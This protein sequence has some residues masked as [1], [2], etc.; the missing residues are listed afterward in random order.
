[1]RKALKTSILT[2]AAAAVLLPASVS[3]ARTSGGSQT[4]TDQEMT[5]REEIRESFRLDPGAAVSVEGIAGPVT[6]ET[7]DGAIA[8]VHIVRM[9]ASRRELDCY[10]TE[11]TGGGARLSIAHVQDRSRGCHSIRSRQQV[12]LT[13]PRA[14]DLSLET[15]AGNV[16]IG[17]IEGRLTLSS[18]AGRVQADGVR[19]ASLSS[20][21]GGLSLTLG[22]L[23]A[24]GVDVSSIVGPTRISFRPGTNADI[25]VSSVQGDVRSLSASLPIDVEN[26]RV[27]ARLGAGGPRVSISSVVGTVELSGS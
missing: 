25:T 11:V 16:A 19:S 13:L 24:R 6:V 2:A 9:A 17:A 26:G 20:I 12:R 22:A 18:I 21:A 7:G 15:V 3:T 27:R 1:M 10:R 8:T 14:V 4:D 23:D 5:A